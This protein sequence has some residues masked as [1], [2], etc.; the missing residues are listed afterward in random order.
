MNAKVNR[1]WTENETRTVNKWIPVSIL[2]V[3]LGVG[4]NFFAKWIWLEPQPQTYA[5]SISVSEYG[6]VLPDPAYATWEMDAASFPQRQLFPWRQLRSSEGK[7]PNARDEI[8]NRLASIDR[9]LR[10]ANAARRDTVIVYLRGHAIAH[11]GQAYL[12]SGDFEQRLLLA[13][14]DT[15]DR[16]S[17]VGR[18]AIAL[19]D[20]LTQLQNVDAA[21]VILLADICDL[22][23]APHLGV[24]ANNVPELIERAVAALP[25]EKPLW[26]ITPSASLQPA[27]AS[28]MRQRTLLQA[29]CE[30]ACQREM[31]AKGVDFLSLSR[32]YEAVLRYSHDVTDGTQTPLLLRSGTSGYLTD[33]S[34]GAREWARASEVRV[35]RVS[36][37]IPDLEDAEKLQKE[38]DPKNP[39]QPEETANLATPQHFVALQETASTSAQPGT[40]AGPTDGESLPAPPPEPPIT[41]PTLKFWKIHDELRQRNNPSGWSPIDFAIDRWQSILTDATELGRRRWLDTDSNT[42]IQT[43]LAAFVSE[44]EQL[45]VA[46]RSQEPVAIA[47]PATLPSAWNSLQSQLTPTSGKLPWN[48]PSVIPS[49]EQQLWE[50]VRNGYRTHLD[51]ASEVPGWLNVGLRSLSDGQEIRRA[52]DNL[53]T[54]LQAIDAKL[55]SDPRDTAFEFPL[56]PSDLSS[57]QASLQELRRILGNRAREAS[58]KLDQV[59]S[60]AKVDFSWHDEYQIQQLLLNTPLSFDDRRKLTEAYAATLLKPQLLRQPG[61]AGQPLKEPDLNI[62]DELLGNL[63]TGATQVHLSSW[64]NQFQAALQLCGQPIASSP[65]DSA[66]KLNEWTLGLL[67]QANQLPPPTGPAAQWKHAC[68]NLF[69]LDRQQST[70]AGLI[71][72]VSNDS[73]MHVEVPKGPVQLPST[74]R[75]ELRRRN[76]APVDRCYLKWKLLNA[77]D[78]DASGGPPLTA[79]YVKGSIELAQNV[80]HPLSVSGGRVELQ[81][82]TAIVLS[83]KHEVFKIAVAIADR[84]DANATPQAVELLPPNPNRIELFAKLVN[85]P[86]ERIVRSEANEDGQYILRELSVPAIGGQAKNTY[87]LY[88]TNLSDK[89]KTVVATIYDVQPGGQA[90]GTGR[91]KPAAIEQTKRN[92]PQLPK[93]FVTSGPIQLPKNQ[94]NSAAASG[95]GVLLSFSAVADNA[96]VAA[97]AENAA[98]RRI[99]EFGLVCVVQEVLVENADQPPRLLDIDPTFLWIDCIPDNPAYHRDPLNRLASVDSPA[100]KGTFV[101]DIEVPPD[102]W[103]RWNVKELKAQARLTDAQGNSITGSGKN[104]A[105]LNPEEN[106]NSL[107]L[108][109]REQPLQPIFAHLDLGEYPRALNFQSRVRGGTDVP[110]GATQSFIWLDYNQLICKKPDGTPI[111]TQAYDGAVVIPARENVSADSDGTEISVAKVVMPVQVDLPKINR[112]T[113]VSI[114]LGD[115][116]GAPYLTDRRFVPR[117]GLNG[118]NLQFSA[119]VEDLTAEFSLEN[120]RFDERRQLEVKIQDEPQSA[121]AFDVVFD[122]TPPEIAN[123]ETDTRTLY[124]DDESMQISIAAVDR[125]SA[126]QRVFFAFDREGFNEDEYDIGDIDENRPA[127]QAEFLDGQWVVTLQVSAIEKL[128][129][130]KFTVV[131]RTIDLAGNFQDLNRP[132]IFEWTGQKR[133]VSVPKKKPEVKKKPAAPPPPPAPKKHNVVVEI[134]VNGKDPAYP[135]NTAI[136]GISGESQLNSGG[137][138]IVTKVDE[139]EY[140]ITATY[141]DAFGVAY[142]GKGKTKVTANSG[143][144][145]K[146]DVKRK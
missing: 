23:S 41:D 105:I 66:D 71:V 60:V 12:L 128:S 77:S 127:M 1:S 94:G 115:V 28:H 100:R 52:L 80:E 113:S 10:T 123:V 48:D 67:R 70:A 142:E 7:Q 109:P 120:Y 68:F 46:M 3:L 13:D 143:T 88:L 15:E 20:I 18:S 111:P 86:D 119:S 30:Y 75:C 58:R 29:A 19:S 82:N 16:R 57:A 135:E 139:G 93:Q 121:K 138:W 21:N 55:P 59:N 137:S 65:P 78:F 79:S 92:L 141:S 91:V 39:P 63:G 116:G 108:S 37:E 125:D 62:T 84:A 107:S 146:I 126:V 72:S 76:G 35:A 49:R 87:E 9:D 54:S 17:G 136:S 145:V 118:S 90:A 133:P 98:V 43:E 36:F 53:I 8:Q 117:F 14:L 140:E 89:E 69:E 122:K 64:A 112:P 31:C 26:V 56:Q 102:H 33:I 134:T 47:N 11:R 4:L 104:I 95:N 74:L 96:A 131:C 34:N 5:F 2:T 97:G 32:F 50:Q 101:I 99:G 124:K 51:T 40:D 24:I 61:A 114:K 83:N 106:E 42:R 130:R 25:I 132:A 44:L 85:S 129:P 22:T 27:H 110:S 45:A 6:G 81:F 103:S 38:L 144:R 73:S